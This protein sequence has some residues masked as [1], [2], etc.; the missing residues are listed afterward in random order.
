MTP[1][2]LDAIDDTN[3]LGSRITQG[4]SWR[5]WRAAL[6]AMFGLGMDD[7]ARRPSIASVRGAPLCLKRPSARHGFVAAGG[8][9]SR[10]RWH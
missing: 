4:A 5:P 6:A 10:L 7:I 9:A 8:P 3:L 1:S 2:I